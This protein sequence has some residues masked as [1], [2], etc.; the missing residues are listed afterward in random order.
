MKQVRVTVQEYV[1][2]EGELSDTK[3]WQDQETYWAKLVPVNVDGQAKFQQ[4]GYSQVD[5]I[6]RFNYTLELNL[7]DYRFKIGDTIYTPVAPPDKR[8][9]LSRART[10]IPVRV[11]NNV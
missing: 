6:L 11:D 9:M 4:A 2:V 1:T 5:K 3:E 8:N 10:E 7:S